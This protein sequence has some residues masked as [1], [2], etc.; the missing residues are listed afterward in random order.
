MNRWD[1]M[2]AQVRIEALDYYW[3]KRQLCDK[4]SPEYDMWM[5][6]TLDLH[7]LMVTEPMK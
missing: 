6:M 1:F 2:L 3:Q 4:D 7:A 5:Q